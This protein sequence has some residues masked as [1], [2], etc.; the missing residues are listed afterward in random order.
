[1]NNLRQDIRCSDRDS[2]PANLEYKSKALL[3]DQ[4]LQRQCRVM[5]RIKAGPPRDLCSTPGRAK[6]FS[7][8][9]SVQTGSGAHPIFHPM[10]TGGS[11]SGVK[12]KGREDH[13]SP[14]QSAEF[15]NVG[16]TTALPIHGTMFTEHEDITKCLHGAEPFLRSR[17]S[18]SYSRTS[19]PFIEP[20]GSLT[21]HT[22]SYQSVHTT[23]FYLSKIHFNIIHPSTS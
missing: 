19:Q 11:F 12:W 4:H 17:Q 1:M 9:H 16:A 21:C 13:H 5:T 20:E 22:E 18:R 15:K 3:L 23:P 2:N 6:D 7:L 10:G 14:Q 8:L